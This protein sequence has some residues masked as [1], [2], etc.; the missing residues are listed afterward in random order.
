DDHRVGGGQHAVDALHRR[1]DL[2]ERD[3]VPVLVQRMDEAQLLV[4]RAG[5]LDA[6]GHQVGGLVGGQG[7]AQG[8]GVGDDEAVAAIGGVDLEAADAFDLDHGVQLVG[9]GRHVLHLD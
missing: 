9:E 6:G 7:E 5:D 1:G 8:A 2:A 3:V 4:G